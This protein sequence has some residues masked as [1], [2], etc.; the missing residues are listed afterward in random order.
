MFWVEIWVRGNFGIVR[1][2]RGRE[3]I[4]RIVGESFENRLEEPRLRSILESEFPRRSGEI[5]LD[6]T[7]EGMRSNGNTKGTK[8]KTKFKLILGSP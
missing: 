5:F 7:L 3:M 6:R 1:S 4:L 8:F 2:I